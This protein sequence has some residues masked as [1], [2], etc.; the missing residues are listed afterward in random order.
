MTKIF[1]SVLITFLSLCYVPAG[2]WTIEAGTFNFEPVNNNI[3]VMHGPLSLPTKANHGFMN[4]PAFVETQNGLVIIDPGSTL[5]VG[6]A[7]LKEIR[8]LTNK[9]VLAIFNTHIHGDHWLANQSV[10]AQYPAIE[11]YAHPQ[12]IE[13]ANG[14]EGQNWLG[15]M[16]RLTEGLSVGTKVVPPSTSVNHDQTITIDGEHFKIHSISPAHTDSD[17]MVEHVE[18][19]TMFL[20]DNCIINRIGRFDGSSSMLGNIKA[21]EYAAAQSMKVYV[22]SHGPS[23]S[24][25]NSLLPYLDYLTKLNKYVAEGLDNDML[26]Y[27]IKEAILD[28]FTDQKS[29][30]SFNELF[31]VNVNKMYLEIEA[32][33]F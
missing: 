18:S 17:I 2:A 24:A 31:G 23:G 28:E 4:N 20:G 22:P 26:D 3:F 6:N 27:E 7:V 29:W 1:T 33:N 5:E 30:V 12:L 11:I 13:Q 10:L 19:Q 16:D 8:L 14:S 25:E 32:S 9:P 21:L 15:L